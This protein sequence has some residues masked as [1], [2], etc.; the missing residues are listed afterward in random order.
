MIRLYGPSIGFGSF[1][2]VAGGIRSALEA[3]GLLAGF[4]PI[5]AY[6][7]EAVYPGHDAEIGVYVGPPYGAALLSGIGWHKKRY[8]FLVANSSWI[9]MNVLRF[10]E[11]HLTAFLCPSS[12][13]AD[14][15]RAYTK[16]PVSVWHHGIASGFVPDK[17]KHD[18]LVSVHR[19]SRFGVLHLSSTMMERKGTKELLEAWSEAVRQGLLGHEPV[20]RVIVD[21]PEGFYRSDLEACAMGDARVF[22]SIVW[23]RPMNLPASEAAA[24]YRANHLVIQPSRSEG[25]GM[26][27][28]EARACGVVT[29]M[30]HG[31]GHQDHYDIES[32]QGV[33]LIRSG[34]EV[35]IDDGPG[36]LAPQLRSTDVY[37]ALVEAYQNWLTYAWHA[38]NDAERIRS[39][40]NWLKTTRDWLMSEGIG[41]KP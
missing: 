34:P 29:A 30:T 12:W 33:V 40:W 11:Q 3:L 10:M 26:I 2:R 39:S 15:L 25:F 1:A 20:L 37:D 23:H 5:D 19:S 27:P 24:L 31:T 18:Q 22:K 21:A 4:V 28:L 8:G 16:F 35:L 9:P 38:Q 7:D 13:A 14:I 32:D 17:Q 41:G 36:A 6:D